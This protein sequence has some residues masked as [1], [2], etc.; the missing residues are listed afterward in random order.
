MGS[1]RH[2]SFSFCTIILGIKFELVYILLMYFFSFLINRKVYYS[3]FQ[4]KTFPR[5]IHPGII[6]QNLKGLKELDCHMPLSFCKD[7]E[8]LFNL[9]EKS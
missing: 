9:T 5:K 8:L 1:K 2:L 7:K 3:A 6:L 4:N